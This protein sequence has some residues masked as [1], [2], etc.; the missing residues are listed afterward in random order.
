[1]SKTYKSDI[2]AAIHETV[3][4]I[5]EA[6][7]FDKKTMRKYD[8]LCL[9]KVEPLSSDEIRE[10]RLSQNVSQSVFALYLNVSKGLISQWERGEKKPSGAS[11]K[12]LSLVK[13]NGLDA[14]A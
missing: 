10:L 5:H 4:D 11:L 9:T 3:S 7:V 14:I 13:E 1:M 6:Q 8:D 2:L 12:L